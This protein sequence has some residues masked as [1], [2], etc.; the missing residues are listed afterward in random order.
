[1]KQ[2]NTESFLDVFNISANQLPAVPLVD[3]LFVSHLVYPSAVLARPE[4]IV[5][6]G[7]FSHGNISFKR[8][9]R[10]DGVF[11]GI[12]NSTT[13]QGS[14]I[15]GSNGSLYGDVTNVLIVLVEANG[16]INGNIACDTVIVRAEAQVDGN[17]SCRSFFADSGSIINGTH[18]PVGG[19]YPFS[20]PMTILL[21]LVSSLPGE[22]N[23]L[24]AIIPPNACQSRD[25]AVSFQS[26]SSST[27][28]RH[29]NSTS[30]PVGKKDFLR[31]G[32]FVLVF[33]CINL[34]LCSTCSLCV[35]EPIL[36][37]TK[38]ELT[39]LCICHNLTRTCTQ[40]P[41]SA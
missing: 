15:V 40:A 32:G 12:L 16:K 39:S 24:S 38:A 6:I 33:S 35:P 30:T 9:V 1:M 36:T 10:I 29:S 26:S 18:C 34:L 27:D 28:L 41:L 13:K 23:V 3:S 19:G 20:L 37:K 14:V 5:G 11:N 7:S 31:A 22:L 25:G 4:F 2:K 17:I 8:L 21:R